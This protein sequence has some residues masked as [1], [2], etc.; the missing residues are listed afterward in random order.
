MIEY[1]EKCKENTQHSCERTADAIYIEGYDQQTYLDVTAYFC[2]VC[3]NIK[4]NYS[5]IG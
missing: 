5:F 4:D 3:L 1:C 2:M